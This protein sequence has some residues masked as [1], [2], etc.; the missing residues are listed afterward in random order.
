[1][2]TWAGGGGW[3]MASPPRPR[4]SDFWR[5]RQP[6]RV[7]PGNHHT[8]IQNMI[9]YQISKIYPKKLGQTVGEILGR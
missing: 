2:K 3:A 5:R 4:H 6:G 7:I 9:Y 8:K 1:M